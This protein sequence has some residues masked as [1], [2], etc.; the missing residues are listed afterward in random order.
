MK[1]SIF[2]IVAL[3]L[4]VSMTPGSN[5]QSGWSIHGID[6]YHIAFYNIIIRGINYDSVEHHLSICLLRRDNS[7]NDGLGLIIFKFNYTQ[8]PQIDNVYLIINNKTTEPIDM[9]KNYTIVQGEYLYPYSRIIYICWFVEI[10]FYTYADHHIENESR[11]WTAFNAGWNDSAWESQFPNYNPSDPSWEYFN[12]NNDS[13]IIQPTMTPAE[14][15]N[16]SIIV[17]MRFNSEL[18]FKLNSILM[19]FTTGIMIG[20]IVLFVVVVPRINHYKTSIASHV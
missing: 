13:I 17:N 19:G 20:V 10:F 12:F 15:I 6:I 8:I 7:W 11:F 2:V 4:V 1:R 16:D 3:C 14:D 9:M 18:P 5:A